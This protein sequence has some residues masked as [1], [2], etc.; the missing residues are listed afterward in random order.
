MISHI[1]TNIFGY[2]MRT[3]HSGIVAGVIT[4]EGAGAVSASFAL[5]QARQNSARMG[6]PI[7]R[8]GTNEAAPA[9]DIHFKL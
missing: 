2:I 8:E 1:R 4:P 9:Y 7:Y 3:V 5:R 6:T